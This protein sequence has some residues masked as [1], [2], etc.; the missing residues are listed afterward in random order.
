MQSIFRH[1]LPRKYAESFTSVQAITQAVSWMLGKGGD[2][3]VVAN[4]ECFKC[5]RKDYFISGKFNIRWIHH[6]TLVAFQRAKE[7]R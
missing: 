3:H 5:L 7:E 4:I 1:D 2:G 6:N